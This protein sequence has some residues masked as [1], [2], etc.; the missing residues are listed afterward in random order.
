M[1][2]LLPAGA[3]VVLIALVAL[4]LRQSQTP[5][6]PPVESTAETDVAVEAKLPMIVVLPFENLGAP[7]D[8][9]F[10]DGMT[11]EITSRL[12][13]VS[14]L[15]VISRTSAMQY[16]EN[17]PS[18]KQV[19]E[20]LG[21]DYVLEGTVRW[22]KP[23]EGP[24]RVR[25]TPELIRVSDDVYLWS[26]RYDRTLEEI[27]AVQSAVAEEV[28]DRVGVQ[29]LSGERTAIEARP[30]ENL[31]AYEAYLRGLNRRF[32]PDYSES[33][34]RMAAQMFERAIQLDPEFALAH[35]QLSVVHS[36]LFWE[37][38]DP[39]NKRLA[40][41][42]KAAE[43]ALELDPSSPHAHIAMGFYHYYGHRDY[44]L[45]LDEF[46]TAEILLP[47]DAEVHYKIGSVLRRQSRFEEAVSEYK[48]AIELNP[49]YALIHDEL[50]LI[51]VF[52]RRYEEA[53]HSYSH[54][55]VSMGLRHGRFAFR[56]APLESCSP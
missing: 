5:T 48:K 20:E 35:A 37:K 27:F 39:T 51:Y 28:I 53:E 23:N 11:E 14:G 47:S 24:T 29:L 2:W 26:E 22:E 41:A 4:W 25:V 13:A 44:E 32:D 19:G 46:R 52:L 15:G 1:W 18:L 21:V 9:Y 10:A 43:R 50:G 54:R 34:F 30:T 40:Q 3:A 56:E 42:R 36:R 45:A 8:E 55:N 31:D 16:K 12:A 6:A 17:R 49:R 33:N 38:Y 7:E